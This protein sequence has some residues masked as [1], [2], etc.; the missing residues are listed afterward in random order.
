MIASKI[1]NLVV[2]A[3]TASLLVKRKGK[4]YLVASTKIV[5]QTPIVTA[6]MET[7][8][9]ENFAALALPAPSSF[10]TLTLYKHH[11]KVSHIKD[12]LAANK[13]GAKSKKFE[14]Q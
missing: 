14:I 5:Q 7:T 8:N 11:L 12:Y 6:V 9:T 3:A 2:S 4:L 10:D 1:D 13:A